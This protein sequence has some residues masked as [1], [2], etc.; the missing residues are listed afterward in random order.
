MLCCT[1]SPKE[2]MNH[3]VAKKNS[4]QR[5]SKLNNHLPIDT[6]TQYDNNFPRDE[7]CF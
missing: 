1:N 5:K 2:K 7:N 3:I 6:S 4:K